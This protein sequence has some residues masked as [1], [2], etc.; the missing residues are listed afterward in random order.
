MSECVCVCSLLGR[1][2]RVQVARCRVLP[3]A[4]SAAPLPLSVCALRLSFTLTYS[5]LAAALPC[6]LDGGHRRTTTPLWQRAR[7]LPARFAG[8][9]LLLRNQCGALRTFEPALTCASPPLRSLLRTVSVFCRHQSSPATFPPSWSECVF[10]CEGGGEVR[11][12]SCFFLDSSLCS[13][14]LQC[15]GTLSSHPSS[16]PRT[17]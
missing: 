3:S 2:V 14:F 9:F 10:F 15:F 12:F 7:F 5:L 6:G 13:S 8:V 4:T 1:R 11:F 16:P 17:L